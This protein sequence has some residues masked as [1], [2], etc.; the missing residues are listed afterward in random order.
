MCCYIKRFI[1]SLP[2]KMCILLHCFFKHISDGVLYC[3]PEADVFIISIK[4]GY[5][6]YH[7]L[8]IFWGGEMNNFQ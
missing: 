5:S 1:T 3:K 2:V 4:I 8:S 7:N 6:P